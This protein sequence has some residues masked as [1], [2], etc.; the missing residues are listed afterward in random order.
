[1]L[2]VAGSSPVSATKMQNAV[3]QTDTSLHK[4]QGWFLLVFLKN[5]RETPPVSRLSLL[6]FLRKFYSRLFLL[7]QRILE[8]DE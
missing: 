8:N 4:F 1:M 2:E 7:R 3:G 6:L 5:L